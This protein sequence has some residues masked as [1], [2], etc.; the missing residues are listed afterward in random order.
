MQVYLTSSPRIFSSITAK[1]AG[2][3]SL[4]P[5]IYVTA[6]QRQSIALDEWLSLSFAGKQS[7]FHFISFSEGLAHQAS[8]ALANI[9]HLAQFYSPSLLLLLPRIAYQTIYLYICLGFSHVFDGIQVKAS[10][11]PKEVKKDF[12][13]LINLINTW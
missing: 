1:D 10:P 7:E 2:S 13:D 8:I 11:L 3:N 6:E 9:T 4:V 12:L 5:Y